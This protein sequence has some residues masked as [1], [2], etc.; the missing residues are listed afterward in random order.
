MSLIYRFVLFNC[1]KITLPCFSNRAYNDTLNIGIQHNN[2][3][4][5][6][7]EITKYVRSTAVT[8]SRT[9]IVEN[10]FSIAKLIQM[11]FRYHGENR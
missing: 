3:N 1:T 6:L 5:L 8:R 9:S 11:H 7:I 2:S 10:R 4:G